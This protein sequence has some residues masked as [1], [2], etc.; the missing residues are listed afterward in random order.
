MAR[1]RLVNAR[2]L[3]Q[4]YLLDTTATAAV[5][6]G[7]SLSSGYDDDFRVARRIDDGSYMGRSARVEKDAIYVRCAF[8]VGRLNELGLLISG[9]MTEND[10]T[11][12]FN[13]RDLERAARI[14]SHGNS[15]IWLGSRLGAMHSL[16]RVLIQEWHEPPGMYAIKSEQ[17]AWGET[18]FSRDHLVVV[19][20]PREQGAKG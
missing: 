17:N 9:Q 12:I 8:E 18:G 2:F 6:A 7:T 1:G 19:F 3:A 16:R 5:P 4:L 15:T 20:R 13:M 14:D 10:V 11:C